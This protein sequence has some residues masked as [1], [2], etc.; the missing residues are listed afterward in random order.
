MKEPCHL[1]RYTFL[2]SHRT[3]Q[4]RF[5]SSSATRKILCCQ[6]LATGG[7]P[8]FSKT[9]KY[10]LVL[11]GNL[12][13][14][15]CVGGII[16]TPLTLLVEVPWSSYTCLC[17]RRGRAKCIVA[18][19]YTWMLYHRGDPA[20]TGPPSGPSGNKA[21]SEERVRHEHGWIEK[22][23]VSF[24]ASELCQVVFSG[25]LTIWFLGSKNS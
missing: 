11:S 1:I 3:F 9:G 25:R 8:S 12:P 6:D 7:F 23:S 19:V 10:P 13:L 4:V 20:S 14:C 24:T 2:K 22:S 18:S 21:D 17:H 16:W 5:C 15:G